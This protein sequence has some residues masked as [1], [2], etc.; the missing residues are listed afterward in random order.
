VFANNSDKIM[1]RIQPQFSNAPSQNSMPT[2]A[3]PCPKK[4]A[5]PVVHGR[6]RA[7]GRNELF[8]IGVSGCGRP[9]GPRT[10][11]LRRLHR[12]F[13]ILRLLRRRYCAVR[14]LREAR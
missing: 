13:V 6:A 14:I 2:L 4:V 3:V 12:Y 7:K 8:E 11:G 10:R 9:R 5:R 1:S